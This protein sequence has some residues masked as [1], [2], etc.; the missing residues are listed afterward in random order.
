MCTHGEKIDKPAAPDKAHGSGSVSRTRRT[1]GRVFTIS[2]FFLGCRGADAV[3]I[4][5]DRDLAPRVLALAGASAAMSDGAWSAM[6]NPAATAS[7]PWSCEVHAAPAPF[8]LAELRTAGAIVTM[9][10]GRV[11]GMP[12]GVGCAIAMTGFDLYR[13]VGTQVIAGV[14]TGPLR[15][16]VALGGNFVTIAGY[17]SDGVLTID[18]GVQA[19]CGAGVTVGARGR[20]LNG[21]RHG[22]TSNVRPPPDIAVGVL[23][24][25]DTLFSVAGDATYERG[26]SAGWRFGMSWTPVAEVTLRAGIAGEPSRAAMGLG[27]RLGR[28]ALDLAASAHPDLGWTQSVGVEFQP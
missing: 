15:W 4:G 14:L 28:L 11:G 23:W 1:A 17:G 19:D 26:G 24:R 20:G 3:A 16:G 9:P 21:P 13:E 2:M 8:G 12:A 6:T 18:A 27:L 10:M 7:L 5:P 25:P 22:A